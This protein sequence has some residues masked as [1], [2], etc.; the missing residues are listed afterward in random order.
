MVLIDG[1]KIPRNKIAAIAKKV[2]NRCNYLAKKSPINDSNL[3]TGNGKLA[4]TSG[5]T[6]NE[7][8]N[9][10]KIPK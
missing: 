8:V 4:V 7:F 1:E 10:Y 6:I 2:L 9:K 3:K 5:L